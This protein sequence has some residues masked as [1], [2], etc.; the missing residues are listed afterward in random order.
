M[1][2]L[3]FGRFL[4]VIIESYA[5]EKIV[6]GAV[7]FQE[8]ADE[9]EKNFDAGGEGFKRKVIKGSLDFFKGVDLGEK[10]EFLVDE[11]LALVE[12]DGFDWGDEF[13]RAVKEEMR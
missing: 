10:I 12:D 3:P 6:L 5:G 1:D 4:A 7:F 8:N 2:F 9:T 13:A 11:F